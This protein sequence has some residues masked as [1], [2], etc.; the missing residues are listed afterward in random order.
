[1]LQA[2]KQAYNATHTHT[3]NNAPRI[4]GGGGGGGGEENKTK[5][6]NKN[7]TTMPRLY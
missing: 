6:N 4:A 3:Q 7:R 2:L 5:N 1:M